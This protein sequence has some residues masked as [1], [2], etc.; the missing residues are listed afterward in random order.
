LLRVVRSRAPLKDNPIF[1]VND[2]E[3][4]DSTI[5]NAIDVALDELCELL[6]I[7]A[8]G[9]SESVSG[10]SMNIERH[11]RLPLCSA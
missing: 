4:A 1:R 2:M 11:A 9:K 8:D 5:G 10:E 7:L 6:G 3:I